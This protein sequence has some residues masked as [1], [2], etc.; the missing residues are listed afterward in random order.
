MNAKEHDLPCQYPRRKHFRARAF[1]KQL[2]HH[3]Q[4][5]LICLRLL[6]LRDPRPELAWVLL[7]SWFWLR[8]E[9]LERSRFCRDCHVVP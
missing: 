1:R 2:D 4:C 3:Y 8:D 6:W 9:G 7:S 5:Q